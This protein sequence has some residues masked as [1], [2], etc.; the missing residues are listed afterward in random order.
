M[1]KLAFSS[2]HFLYF[3]MLVV[4]PGSRSKAKQ[5][6]KFLVNIFFLFIKNYA[7]HRIAVRCTSRSWRLG[8]RLIKWKRPQVGF[9]NNE[10]LTLSDK[11]VEQCYSGCVTTEH[12]ITTCSYT[13]HSHPCTSENLKRSFHTI[14]KCPVFLKLKKKVENPDF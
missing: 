9:L 6:M 2:T 10:I 4:M 1:T 8:H 11:E 3:Y 5:P 12:V 7:L 14:W 13:I